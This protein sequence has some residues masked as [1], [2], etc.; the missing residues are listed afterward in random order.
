MNWLSLFKRKKSYFYLVEYEIVFDINSK[1][2]IEGTQCGIYHTDTIEN[3]VEDIRKY[4]LAMLG[5]K[6]QNF[7]A[8]NV[9][10][11]NISKL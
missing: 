10:I 7:I 5:K 2:R 4:I 6:Y 1:K 9:E 11:V 3:I 8:Y